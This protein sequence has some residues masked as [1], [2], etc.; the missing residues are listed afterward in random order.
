MELPNSRNLYTEREREVSPEKKIQLF[1]LATA[2]VARGNTESRPMSDY[3]YELYDASG[4]PLFYDTF[5]DQDDRQPWL[6]L[7]Y[8]GVPELYIQRWP[9]RTIDGFIFPEQIN[10]VALSPRATHDTTEAYTMQASLQ[11]EDER[12]QI[13]NRKE[14]QRMKIEWLEISSADAQRIDAILTAAM[15]HVSRGLATP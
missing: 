6:E 4:Q 14:L 15:K 12:V 2:I 1:A 5:P 9:E 11:G 3:G 13:T 10:I 7:Q 8:V